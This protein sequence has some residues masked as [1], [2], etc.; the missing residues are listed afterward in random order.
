MK[1]KK[2]PGWEECPKRN[3][4]KCMLS[5]PK[6]FTLIA[7]RNHEVVKRI[8]VYKV[9]DICLVGDPAIIILSFWNGSFNETVVCDHIMK[10][11]E[12]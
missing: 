12:K 11:V 6:D 10:E 8:K 9:R 3:G 1:C 5:E 2:C 7:Y 4:D